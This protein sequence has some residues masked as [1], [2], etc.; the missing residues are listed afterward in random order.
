VSDRFTFRRSVIT[1]VDQL[2]ELPGSAFG[3]GGFGGP[4]TNLGSASAGLQPGFTNSQSIL[5]GSGERLSNTS[6]LELDTY[7]TR[8]SQVTFVG[9]YG[10]L[11]YIKDGLLNSDQES[12][13]AGYN[14][15]LN[16][17]DSLAV[18]YSFDGFRYSH[19]AQSIDSHSVQLS[20]G[21]RVT[22]KMAFQLTGGP[23]LSFS[24]APIT[25]NSTGIVSTTTATGTTRTLF[26]DLGATLTYGWRR[27]QL[28]MEYD[29]DV[30]GGSGVLAGA[31]TDNLNGTVAHQIRRN[32][33]GTLTFGYSRNSGLTA[34]TTPGV[35]GGTQTFNYWFADVGMNRTFGRAINASIGYHVQSQT[36]GAVSCGTG[37]CPAN[38]TESLIYLSLGWR[39]RPFN[40]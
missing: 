3:Y 9:S 18:F 4:S 8:R 27:T 20:Y 38:I 37:T 30:T 16:R 5:T 40:F 13:Q 6:V 28:T 39:P 12:F 29:H 11:D 31:L 34:S 17:K 1:A 35:T 23:A 32:L 2:V 25:T 21:R 36:G 24:K 15:V 10:L 19:I 26:W 14:Y 22:G 7:L 33:N